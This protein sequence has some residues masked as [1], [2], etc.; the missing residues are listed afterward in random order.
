MEEDAAGYHIIEKSLDKL[1]LSKEY[2]NMVQE[3]VE[4]Y[5]TQRINAICE[6]QRNKGEEL[7]EW[8]IKKLAGLRENVSDKVL[9][10][11]EVWLKS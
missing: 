1:P 9:N 3:S 4:E 5:Q 7:V 8:K 10:T 2:L 11:I 6:G